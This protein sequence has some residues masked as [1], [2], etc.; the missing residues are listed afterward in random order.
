MM[1]SRAGPGPGPGPIKRPDSSILKIKPWSSEMGG[2]GADKD[3]TG[4]GYHS[5][6]P[7]DSIQDSYQSNLLVDSTRQSR[8]QNMT[9]TVNMGYESTRNNWS[10]EQNNVT[11]KSKYESVTTQEPSNIPANNSEQKMSMNLKTEDIWEPKTNVTVKE[12][13]NKGGW[14]VWGS[15]P[16][17]GWDDVNEIPVKEV[18]IEKGG[19]EKSIKMISDNTE[20]DDWGKVEDDEEWGDVKKVVKETDAEVVEEYWDETPENVVP[21]L[22]GETLNV[23]ENIHNAIN[24]STAQSSSSL[25]EID[26][27]IIEHSPP[28]TKVQ[29][30]QDVPK[31]VDFNKETLNQIQAE[32]IQAFQSK[33]NVDPSKNVS[34]QDVESQLKSMNLDQKYVSDE[35]GSPKHVSKP[36][37]AT[38]KTEEELRPSPSVSPSQMNVWNM[39]QSYPYV[40]MMPPAYMMLP[41]PVVPPGMIY[42][43]MMPPQGFIPQV[44]IGAEMSQLSSRPSSTESGEMASHSPSVDKNPNIVENNNMMSSTQ[45]E[46]HVKSRPDNV[47]SHKELV[48]PPGLPLSATN[49]PIRPSATA[50]QA[51][52]EK[53]TFTSKVPDNTSCNVFQCLVENLSRQ[54]LPAMPDDSG[55][56]GVASAPDTFRKIVKEMQERNKYTLSN[57][58]G[59]EGSDVFQFN[60]DQNNSEPRIIHRR[61]S[62][63]GPKSRRERMNALQKE[64]MVEEQVKKMPKLNDHNEE[65]RRYGDSTSH[66]GCHGDPP[67]IE[68]SRH[69]QG[70]TPREMANEATKA[71]GKPKEVF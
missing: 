41:Y 36:P 8:H 25:R 2:S 35:E 4:C 1:T 50:K 57:G 11:N 14:S 58:Y 42:Q 9:D 26:S 16:S 64:E 66:N 69:H 62:R 44:N 20:D 39:S 7:K 70:D 17:G 40:P 48:N 34:V 52:D 37:T 38:P 24:S 60:A 5:Y 15:R 43:T 12:S 31:G 28:N 18:K 46:P 53:D 3:S 33:Q 61:A 6:T 51:N 71:N 45:T 63:F 67:V 19:S 21:Q 49:S 22:Y 23:D 30:V 59:G 27:S 56:K 65:H 55:K 68:L 10:S 54:T 47:N 29:D 13:P 32:I